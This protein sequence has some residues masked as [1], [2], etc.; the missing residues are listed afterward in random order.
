MGL[1]CGW[2]I[3]GVEQF[4]LDR[5]V[6][7]N[8]ATHG[9]YFEVGVGFGPF[10]HIFKRYRSIAFYGEFTEFLIAHL[11]IAHIDD[12]RQELVFCGV[13]DWVGVNG[14]Q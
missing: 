7:N 2:F 10:D 14:D 8:V 6:T 3:R 13:H 4:E 1:G 12:S 9:G 5:G 11:H